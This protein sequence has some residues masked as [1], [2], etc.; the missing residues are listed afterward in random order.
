M[1]FDAIDLKAG[2]IVASTDTHTNRSIV[3]PGFSDVASSSYGGNEEQGFAEL[4]YHLP[5]LGCHVSTRL[6]VHHRQIRAAVPRLTGSISARR[7]HISRRGATGR[8]ASIG[9]ELLR[10]LTPA[11]TPRRWEATSTNHVE[12]P[13]TPMLRKEKAMSNEREKT[14]GAPAGKMQGC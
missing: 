4:G 12:P 8:L 6:E 2:A 3:F 10:P 13:M 9:A 11:C 5:F 1:S 14:D 7:I